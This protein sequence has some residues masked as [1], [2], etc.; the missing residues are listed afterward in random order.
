MK[1]FLLKTLLF[2]TFFIVIYLLL[3][4][5]NFFAI[6]N[7]SFKIPTEKTCVVIGA[8]QSGAAIDDSLI[9]NVFNFS[10]SGDSY[11]NQSI[12]LRHLLENNPQIKTVFISVL[13]LNLL[14]KEN[15]LGPEK[16]GGL[17]KTNIDIYYPLHSKEEFLYFWERDPLLYCKSVLSSPLRIFYAQNKIYLRELGYYRKT[18]AACLAHDKRKLKQINFVENSYQLKY[19][20]K[21]VETAQ[22]NNVKVYFISCPLYRSHEYFEI[23]KFHN[24]LKKHFPTIKLWDY[25]DFP[26]PDNCRQDFNHLNQYGAEIFSRELARRIEAEGLN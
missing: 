20:K 17:M 16:L 7:L 9:S 18:A 10:M 3:I 21:L 19:L 4:I 1:K 2:S 24:V 6:R 25:E 15:N 5:A 14:V 23:D 12:R 8:S 13:P 22:K 26:I 11:F